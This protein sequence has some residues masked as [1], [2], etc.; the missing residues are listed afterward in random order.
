MV[1]R[2]RAARWALL[3]AAIFLSPGAAVAQSAGEA[4][5]AQPATAPT[6]SKAPAELIPAASVAEKRAENAELLRVAERKVESDPADAAAAAELAAYKTTET[7]LAQQ[8][9]VAE[10]VEDLTAREAELRGELAA[11]SATKNAPSDAVSFVEFDRLVN[12]LAAERARTDLVRSKLKAAKAALELAQND[13]DAREKDRRQAVEALEAGKAGPDAAARAAAVD[14]A[15]RASGLAADT[16]ALRKKELEREK[17]VES[18]HGLTVELLQGKVD[19]YQPLVKF[20]DTE[21]QGQL[22]QLKAQEESVRSALKQAEDDAT[23]SARSWLQAKNRLKAAGGKDPVLVEEVEAWQRAR[24]AAL[25]R[26]NAALDQLLQ[27]DQ[28]RTAWTRLNRLMSGADA[29]SPNE[30][31]TWK[32]ETAAALKVLIG[33]TQMH[34]LRIDELRSE[35]ATI[36]AKA[37]AA[38]DGP[39]ELRRNIDSQRGS[40]EAMIRTHEANLVSI[41][42][43]RRLHGKLRTE[44]GRGIDVLSPAQWAHD[45]GAG[46][47]WLWDY[48]LA[49]SGDRSV[50][51]GKIARALLLFGLGWLASRIASRFFAHRLLHRLRLSKDATTVIR[52]FIFYTAVV[53]AALVALRSADVPLTAFTILGGAVAIGVG[54]GSQALVNNFLSGLIMLAERPVRIGERVLFGDFDGVVEDVGFRC[55]KLRTGSDH[56]VTIPNSAMINESIENVGRRRVIRRTMNLGITYDT[57]RERV[58]EAVAAIR[59]I[60]EEPGI[61]EQIHPSIGWDKYPP[62][63]FFQDYLADSLNIQVVYWFAPAD[64]W[65]YMEHAQRVNLRIFE[66]F[67]RLGVSFAFPSRTVYLANDSARALKMRVSS[68]EA[69]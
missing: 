52:T 51:V 10:Q 61:G 21:L 15:K 41:D 18:V 30:L 20:T 68:E 17:L 6:A 67:E 25:E 28:L 60:L 11:W 31:T 14:D 56:L 63:V 26:K 54:F 38:K 59:E 2:K 46:V 35:L 5:M 3:L 32:D 57:P 24:D 8:E 62:R 23:A 13:L 55:T 53:I 48:E 66:E 65:S 16:V 12:R 4:P 44:L 58:E 19:R 50:T 49:P 45:I 47:V 69:A 37:A 33:S 42:A 9:S 40:I 7:I 1:R 34:L 27:I 36:L 43:S 29:L 39:D 22:Q 64:H